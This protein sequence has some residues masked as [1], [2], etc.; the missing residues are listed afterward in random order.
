MSDDPEDWEEE[1]DDDEADDADFD[2]D[3]VDDFDADATYEPHTGAAFDPFEDQPELRRIALVP[4]LGGAEGRIAA[5]SLRFLRSSGDEKLDLILS[6]PDPG[7]LVQA[8]SAEE[9]VLLAKEV[10]ITDVGELLTLASP[11]QLQAVIDLDGWKNAEL[12]ADTF[13]DWLAAARHAGPEVL[14][15]FVA[16]Q[17]DGVLS[18]FLATGM[19]VLIGEEAEEQNI[20][21]DFDVFSSPDMTMQLVVDP[22]VAHVGQMRELIAA[23]YRLSLK[24]GRTVLQALRWELPAQLQEDLHHFR[25]ARIED[26]GFLAQDD[27]RQM[28]AYRDPHAQKLELHQQY[29]GHTPADIQEL[30]PYLPADDALRMGLALKTSEQGG[31]LGQAMAHVPLEHHERL[32]QAIVRLAYRNQ[33]ARAERPAAV[34][35]LAHW[36]R[37][38][39]LTAAMGLEF[40]SAGDL[41]YAGLLLVALPLAELFQTGHSLVLMEHY[42]A[43]R[44]RQSVG[45]SAGL[46][47]LAFAQAALV[48]AMG[49]NFPGL[50]LADDVQ[51]DDT[52]AESRHAVA[53]QP[54]ESLDQLSAVRQQ[55]QDIAAVVRLVTQMAG[56]E[57]GAML[58]NLRE[59]SDPDEPIK[60]AALVNTAIAWQVVDG[61]PRLQHL[62]VTALRRF[63]RDGFAGTP[64]QR[65]VHDALRDALIAGLLVRTDYT[66]EEV[67]AMEG[68][69]TSSLDALAEQFG[70]LDAQGELDVRFLGDRLLLRGVLP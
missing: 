69:L 20:P 60:L 49:Q 8:I 11:R 6:L 24:R 9:F 47:A 12:D 54:I 23:I 55:L 35:E 70:G 5:S 31:F 38:S 59:N 56:G 33:A 36:S 39:L 63:L 62:D 30:R 25:S 18:L 65:R 41:A 26:Y 48:R 45:G 58:N 42:R 1:A 3:A 29:R 19:K 37:H 27:A 16:A 51:V 64:G 66:D 13:C 2:R 68:F 44:I 67:R 52:G 10:D 22:D 46:D 43:K 28:Y 53:N 17:E 57:L 4:L 40:L 7:R 32:R 34:H 14:G 21:D 15:R 50:P 61:K